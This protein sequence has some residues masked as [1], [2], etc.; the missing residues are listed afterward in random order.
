MDLKAWSELVAIKEDMKLRL[1]G[2]KHQ[3]QIRAIHSLVQEARVNPS[4]NVLESLKNLKM[5]PCFGKSDFVVY[6]RYLQ[7]CIDI[8]RNEG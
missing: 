2:S 3:K 1:P 5:I 7:H 6:C 8:L 4:E